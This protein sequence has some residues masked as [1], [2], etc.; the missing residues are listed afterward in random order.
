MIYLLFFLFCHVHTH[1]INIQYN[2]IVCWGYLVKWICHYC[3]GF[4]CNFCAVSSGWCCL[5]NHL[6]HISAIFLTLITEREREREFVDG[7]MMRHDVLLI[8]ISSSGAFH[9]ALWWNQS[10]LVWPRGGYYVDE[11]S[12]DMSEDWTDGRI[13]CMCFCVR[14]CGVGLSGLSPP[15]GLEQFSSVLL[16]LYCV[17]FRY[18]REK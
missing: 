14:M 17:S 6:L 9:T 18:R 13:V 8:H 1:C 10:R 15:L 7:V 2:H 16:H 11:Q 5:A 3:P 12:T 4:V